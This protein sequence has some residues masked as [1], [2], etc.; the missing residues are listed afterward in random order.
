MNKIEILGLG[1]SDID[2]MTVGVLKTLKSRDHVYARTLDHPVIKELQ[3]LGVTFKS[4]DDVYTQHTHFQDVYQA[5]V[6]DLIHAAK[7]ADI[8]YV[9]PGHPYFYETTTELLRQSDVEVTVLGGASFIDAVA[10]AL[11]ISINTHFQVL[12]ATTMAYSDLSANK[13]TLITQVYDQMSL[14]EA[15]L[16]LLEYYEADTEVTLIDR[17]GSTNQT[18]TKLPLHKLDHEEVKSNMLTLYIP[19]IESEDIRNRSIEFMNDVFDMLVDDET[20]CPWDKVQTHESLEGY[21][22]EETYELIEAI[23]HA[24]DDDIIEE[25]GDVLLQVALHSAIGKKNGYFDFYDVLESLNSKVVR[26]HPHIFGE[27]KISN[28]GEL[29]RIW[30]IA[31]EKEGKVKKVKHEK[32]YAKTLLPF[33]KETIHSGTPLKDILYRYRGKRDENR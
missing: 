22:I 19:I 15:K 12:D 11:G 5:I 13:H 10:L 2:S 3:G 21:L 27:E 4:F 18:V 28:V 9:V 23:E 6:D 29:D 20:G 7:D 33:M 30:K 17:A 26:R 14:G 25:L 8:T 31:K 1:S 16:T 32:D 24:R